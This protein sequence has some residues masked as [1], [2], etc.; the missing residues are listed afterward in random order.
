MT[1]PAAFHLMDA[2][3]REPVAGRRLHHLTHIAK[4][5]LALRAEN[6]ARDIGRRKIVMRTPEQIIGRDAVIQLLFEGYDIVSSRPR[7][8][9]QSKLQE[10]YALG[11]YDQQGS[12]EKLNPTKTWPL[13]PLARGQ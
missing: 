12:E 7:E 11:V 8:E 13:T 6:I 5:T 1:A 3:W 10:A 4:L 9:M 2:R